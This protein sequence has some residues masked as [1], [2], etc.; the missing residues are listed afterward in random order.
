MG[1]TFA[2]SAHPDDRPALLRAGARRSAAARSCASS[3][4]SARTTAS[5]RWVLEVGVPRF[6]DG[7]FVG[8]VGTATDIHERKAMEEALRESEQ[9]FRELADQAPVMIWTTDRDGLVTFVN[10][11]WLRFTG[12]TLEQELGDS[13]DARRAPRG[14][15]TG[16]DRAGTRRS[17]RGRPGSGSTGCAA[18]TASTAGS[19]TA[20]C[21]A[22]SDGDFAGY[23]GTAVDIHERKVMEA[24]L[25]E[26]RRARARG[27][28]DAAAQPAAGAAAADATGIELAARYLPAGAGAA[29]GGDWYDALELDDGRVA[30][31]VGDVV[32]H[33]LRAAATMGQLRNAFRAYG[34]V[35]SSPAEVMGRVNRLR[36][37]GDGRAMATVLYLVLDRE[38]GEVSYSSAGHP[39][40]LV[41]AAGRRRASSRAGARCRSAR[42]TRSRFREARATL[43][44]GRDAAA[45]HRRARRAPRHAAGR[46]ARPARAVA[47]GARAASSSELCDEVLAGVLARATPATTSR[48]WRCAL[49]PAGAGRLRSRC[50]PIPPRWGG[51]AGGSARFLRRRR[52]RRPRDFEITLT[53]CEAAGNAIEH[54]YGPGDATFEVAAELRDG[55]AVVATRSRDR[56]DLARAPQ[57]STAAAGSRSSRG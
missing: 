43:A 37:R 26:R 48:C 34:L 29:I 55:E 24:R 18:A 30:V 25:R 40:P 8:Y 54:A 50:P 4:A 33:G 10:E 7:E 3:T 12:T 11:G 9:G 5:Y 21:R 17:P 39:P 2:L 19:S 20:A 36:D 41:L 42:P 31:V 27:R 13:W 49:E 47:G 35:E 44:A 38:T 15:R 16:H 57:E 6:Q 56:G 28:R 32:G 46:P 14:R 22:T 52:R 1:D 51:C 45:L 23:V 53:V